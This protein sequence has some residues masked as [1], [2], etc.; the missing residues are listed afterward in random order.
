[1]ADELSSFGVLMQMIVR[2]ESVGEIEMACGISLG[3]T[4]DLV[5]LLEVGQGDLDNFV[6]N[7]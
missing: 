1:M 4:L 2:C 7:F 3:E 5:V 6:A